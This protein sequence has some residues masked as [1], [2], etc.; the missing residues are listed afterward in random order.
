MVHFFLGTFACKW[1]PCYNDEDTLIMLAVFILALFVCIQQ[2]S[3]FPPFPVCREYYPLLV[4][5]VKH[6]AP[7]LFMWS[8]SVLPWIFKEAVA[9]SFRMCNCCCALSPGQ[10]W[11]N[12][13]EVRR[14]DV[15]HICKSEG[16]ESMNCWWKNSWL[17][18]LMCCKSGFL[19]QFVIFSCT[20]S[21][22]QRAGRK[23][24]LDIL[25]ANTGGMQA[26]LEVRSGEP[27]FL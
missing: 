24:H 20:F 5:S 16:G 11:G 26:P 17:L 9:F 22:F 3:G 8:Q 19:S 12:Q 13:T 25:R 4:L 6:G 10:E 15:P 2:R 27:G 18:V 7:W 14:Q 21:Y 1:G 23:D